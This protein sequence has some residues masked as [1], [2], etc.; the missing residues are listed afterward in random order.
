VL[1]S[2][3]LLTQS[4]PVSRVSG[5][6]LGRLPKLASL[7][8]LLQ[9]LSD[10]DANVI[11]AAAAALA[12]HGDRSVIQSLRAVDGDYPDWLWECLTDAIQT[13]EQAIR[14]AAGPRCSA[15]SSERDEGAE[16]AGK[17]VR[18]Q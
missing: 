3:F 4:A 16:Q 2:V 6:R 10:Q 7:E 13:L 14:F 17:D 11:C 18:A 1:Y 9:A 12:K 5:H 8:P 15:D